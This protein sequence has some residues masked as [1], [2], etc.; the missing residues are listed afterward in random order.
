VRKR[1]SALSILL[2]VAI[3]VAGCSLPDVV[4][5]IEQQQVL[6]TP[7]PRVVVVVATPSPG[8]Q[9]SAP[10]LLASQAAQGNDSEE[11]RRV[12]AYQRVSPAVVNITTQIVRTD[13][14]WGDVP[15]EG[16]GSGF[17]WDREGHV[18]TNYH[19][20]EG[21]QEIS[22]SFGNDVN[23]SAS[24]VGTDPQNDL[25]VLRVKDAPTDVE[26]VQLGASDGLK[27]GQSVYAIGNPFGQFER[28]MTQGIVS[29]LNRTIQTENNRVLR[30]VIQ[31]DAAINR[32]NSGGPL[33]DSSG[34]LIG[35]NSAIYS[36]TGTSAGVG[37]AIP[38]DKVRLVV[39]ELIKSGRYPHPWLGLEELG[40]EISP[41]LARALNLPVQQGLLVARVYQGSPADQAG[42]RTAQ[43]QVILGNRRYL[44]G[45][46]I[47][48]AI[49][50]QPLTKWEQLNA[51]LDEAAHVGQAVTLSVMRNGKQLTLL[52]TLTDTP[53][54]LQ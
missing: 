54:Q 39:P 36:P 30:G 53:E 46:D 44:I 32:G 50:G 29:A 49:D 19:V 31:T 48:T 23:L 11:M 3:S 33:L 17:L 22:V 7:T 8:P 13:F 16:S 4:T 12:A 14:F 28:T 25:A 2:T 42:V 15:E 34:R 37:L 41:A 45:G 26:P 10:P 43:D 21:A 18:V 51:Y 9:V 35:V 38:V 40:Y 27:V 24:V 47:L 6:P 20:V 1:I 52:A 5:A